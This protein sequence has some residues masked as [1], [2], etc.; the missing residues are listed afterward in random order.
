MSYKT[1]KWL[2]IMATCGNHSA[3]LC[4]SS[5]SKKNWAPR[6]EHS[7]SELCSR[8]SPRHRPLPLK[9]NSQLQ[10][11][12][13]SRLSQA[14]RLRPRL[15]WPSLSGERITS[16]ASTPG[17]IAAVDTGALDFCCIRLWIQIKRNVNRKRNVVL[18][19]Q[20]VDDSSEKKPHLM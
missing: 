10:R 12:D 9:K 5:A 1:V 18:P 14:I 2:T 8:K 17:A 3:G 7:S 13:R 16:S 20:G 15:T 11:S 19:R 6:L 4:Y